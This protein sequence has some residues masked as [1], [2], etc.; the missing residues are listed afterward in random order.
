MHV[1]VYRFAII[2]LASVY[3]TAIDQNLLQSAIWAPGYKRMIRYF[4]GS[5][6]PPSIINEIAN[7]EVQG[8]NFRYGYRATQSITVMLNGT[9]LVNNLEFC[10]FPRSEYSQPTFGDDIPFFKSPSL[11][12]SQPEAFSYVIR[13]SKDQKTWLTIIDYSDFPCLGT[14]ILKFP[15][16]AMR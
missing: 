3:F 2:R 9:Y 15:C 12:W 10:G 13:V 7:L 8:L 16:Q 6:Q 1:H 5:T 11:P 14:Q 4:L